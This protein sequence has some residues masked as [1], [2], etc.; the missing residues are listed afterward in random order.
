MLKGFKEF[1]ARGNVIDLAIAVVIGAAFTG[2]VTAFTEN[3]VQ[4]LIIRI[5]A[6]ADTD[7]GIPEDLHWVTDIA[8]DFN[9]V[10]RRPSTS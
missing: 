8:I 5:G 4:P 1:L 10:S 3:V 6:A 2:L 7:Y 9:A